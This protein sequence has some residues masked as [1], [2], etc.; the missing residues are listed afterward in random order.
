MRVLIILLLFWHPAPPPIGPGN[1]PEL[2]QIRSLY[3]QSAVSREAARQL[4]QL[5]TGGDA[6]ADPLLMCYRGAVEMIQAKYVFDPLS[7]FRSFKKGKVLIEEA[8]ARDQNG[9]EM[10]YLRFSI[11]TNLPRFLSY[12]KQIDPDKKFLLSKI[13]RLNDKELKRLIIKYLSHSKYCSQAEKHQ[14]NKLQEI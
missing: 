3:N 13:G 2:K 1:V 12:Y 9:V 11:Q 5:L 8:I 6:N 14:M 10:R 4:Q 7:K